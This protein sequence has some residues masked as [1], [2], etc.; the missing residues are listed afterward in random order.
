M[1]LSDEQ[2][3]AV[4]QWIQEGASLSDVQKRL[5]TEFNKRLTYMDVRFVVDDLDL[6]VSSSGPKFD[7][8]KAT[9]GADGAGN[10]GTEAAGAGSVSVTLDKVSRPDAIVS[11]QVT[12]SDGVSAQWHLDQTGRLAL[13]AQQPGYQPS[14]E[15]LQEFQ[16]QLRQAVEQSGML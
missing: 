2:K 8:L 11:G 10:V 5:E 4:A 15:D 6:E 9:S 16:N 1:S 3:A 14:Q 13:N 7:D 12:F